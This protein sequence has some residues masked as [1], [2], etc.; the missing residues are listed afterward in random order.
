M[1]GGKSN[2]TRESIRKRWKTTELICTSL[3]SCLL[4]DNGLVL[5]REIEKLDGQ[6]A[7]AK[8]LHA[9]RYILDCLLTMHSTINQTGEEPTVERTYVSSFIEFEDAFQIFLGF[10]DPE[11]QYDIKSERRHFKELLCHPRHGLC[12]DVVTRPK[13]TTDNR[14]NV[15]YIVLRPDNFHLELFYQTL[16][17]PV[18]DSN[19]VLNKELLRKLFKSMDTEWD[20]KILRVVL[21]LSRTRKQIDELGMSLDTEDCADEDTLFTRT[22]TGRMAGSWRLSSYIG[23]SNTTLVISRFSLTSQVF[24]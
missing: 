7:Y 13:P 19:E 15:K 14:K 1:D 20:R 18:D 6:S 21:S 22:R 17:G 5:E 16:C 3:Q 24:L 23:E 4:K 9:L 11:V 2:L 10:K 8:N 12:I